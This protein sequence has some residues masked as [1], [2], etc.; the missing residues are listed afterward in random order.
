MTD[1]FFRASVGAVVVDGHRRILV[2]RRKGTREVAW[3]MPQGGIGM[4]ESPLDA[5]H[6]ELNE[7]TGLQHRDVEVVASTRDWL[8]Y[9]LSPEFRN[10]KVGWG[11]SQRWFLCQLL[12]DRGRVHP[13]G[14][15]FTD[16]DW[17]TAEALVARAVSFRAPIYRRLVAEFSLD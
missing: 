2:M 11:Q 7:E 14:V 1:A 6:R 8:V 10:A 3:Q 17:V 9:E 4:D 15:E 13:D 16:V 5:L 12:T